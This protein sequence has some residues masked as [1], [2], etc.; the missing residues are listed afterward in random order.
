MGK[1]ELP[2]L[3]SEQLRNAENDP[4]PEVTGVLL[5][6]KIE[7][8]IEKT[9]LIMLYDKKNIEPASYDLRLGSEC[10]T[11]AKRRL[12][13]DDDPDFLIEPYELAVISIYEN[14]NVPRYLVGRWNIR[15][16]LIYKGVLLVS[17]P[18][19]DPG[20]RGRLYCTIFNLSTTTIRLRYKEHVATIDFA[21]T[22]LFG[23]KCKKFKQKKYQLS[24]Y[25]PS[26][27]LESGPADIRE[28]VRKTEDIVS[29]MENR[30]SAF[31]TVTF[32]VLGIIIAALALMSTSLFTADIRVWPVV[33][34]VILVGIVSLVAGIILGRNG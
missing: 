11:K 32:T 17:G 10:Y 15:I 12:L 30:V 4:F 34:W 7:D 25:L 19:V 27:P 29:R 14:L 22:S 24:E 20:F 3:T 33:I 5:S 18:Q 13:R 16:G 6:D 26:Y 9:G 28:R 1:E 2:E 31:Q 23:K 21:K 8:Y